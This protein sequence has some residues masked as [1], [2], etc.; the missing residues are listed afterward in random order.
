MPYKHPLPFSTVGQGGAPELCQSAQAA[1]EFCHSK[2]LL[3]LYIWHSPNFHSILKKES[4]IN[5]YIKV[6]LHPP[7]IFSLNK[8]RHWSRRYYLCLEDSNYIVDPASVFCCFICL[9]KVIPDSL[10]RKLSWRLIASIII[11]FEMGAWSRMLL[12]FSIFRRSW[13]LDC[14]PTF[15]QIKIGAACRFYNFT[16]TKKC[17]VLSVAHACAAGS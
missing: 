6:A 8:E 13:I 9:E 10:Q 2:H 12:G 4:A 3:T 5:N 11:Y 16:H 1:S 7:L 15:R 14:W 17:S